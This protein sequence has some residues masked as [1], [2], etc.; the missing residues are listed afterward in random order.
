MHLK[1]GLPALRSIHIWLEVAFPNPVY[2]A[3]EVLEDRQ[4]GWVALRLDD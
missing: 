4:A 2:A 1:A 3:F